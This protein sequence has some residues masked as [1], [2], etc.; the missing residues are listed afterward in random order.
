M[1]FTVEF[2]WWL[3][4]Q[5]QFRSTFIAANL[6]VIQITVSQQKTEVTNVLR[7]KGMFILI[8]SCEYGLLDL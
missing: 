2:I 4:I 5:Y 7:K 6:F 1:Y 8:T 3:V